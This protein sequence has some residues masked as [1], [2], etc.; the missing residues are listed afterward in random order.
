MSVISTKTLHAGPCIFC[1]EP[2]RQERKVG[3]APTVLICHPCWREQTNGH[4]TTPKLGY[5]RHR[6]NQP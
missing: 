6:R 2:T 1:R 4:I 5:R 3:N